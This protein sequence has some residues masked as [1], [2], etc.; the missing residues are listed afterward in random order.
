[1]FWELLIQGVI[2]RK[3]LLMSREQNKKYQQQEFLKLVNYCY[4]HSPYYR[5]IIQKFRIDIKNCKVENFPQLSK[6]DLLTHF[7]EIITDKNVTREKIARFLEK[8]KDPTELL[9]NKYI[10]IHTSGS[11]GTVS[12]YIFSQPDFIKGINV[13][14]RGTGVRLRQK[15]AF[16]A[17]THGHFAG[18][19]MSIFAKNFPLLYKDV[20]LLDINSPFDEII[21]KLNFYKPTI[22]S[23]YGFALRQLAQAQKSGRLKISPKLLQSGGEP[24]RE[25]DKE[26]IKNIFNKPIINIYASSEHLYMGIGKDEYEGMYLMEDKLIFELHEN[27][28]LVTNLYNYTLPLIR[29]RMNDYLVPIK[30]ST[31]NMPFT[32]IKNIVGR[33]ET[34]PFFINDEGME[35]FISPHILGEFYVKDLSQF[36]IQ[37]TGKKSFIFKAHLE[38]KLSLMQKKKVVS[39]IH[40]EL[41]KILNEKKMSKVS[42]KIKLVDQFVVNPKTGKFSL[43][44]K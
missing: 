6:A 35:D 39:K 27:Y 13:A 33:N 28:S 9:D 40:I 30:D 32:K 18:V 26:Y 15:L 1:M 36:Q 2:S 41:G 12:Y 22:L 11:S 23:G 8:S 14:T 17:A 24:L 21:K 34:V 5:K 10:V 37:I 38:D 31:H 7:N 44:L 20:L 16:V 25:D 4:H 3:N 19:T 29:Y 43:I 42:F